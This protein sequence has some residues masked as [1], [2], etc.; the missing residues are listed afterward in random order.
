MVPL[1]IPLRLMFF[2]LLALASNVPALLA[3]SP[4]D[5]FY[6]AYYLETARG[7]V[8]GAAKLYGQV[9]ATRGAPPELVAQAKS[10]LASCDEDLAAADF[11]RLM[12]PNP[13]AYIELNRPGERVRKLLGQ[14]GLLAEADQPPVGHEK[15]VAVSPAL[16]EAFCGMRGVAAAVTGFDPAH[17]MPTG[18]VVF[19]PGNMEIARGLIETALPAGTQPTDP[20]AGYPT[21]KVADQFLVTLTNRLVIA[22]SQEA[23]I[24]AVIDRLK[25]PSADSL[26]TNEELAEIRNERGDALLFFFVNPK[27]LLPLL[28]GVLAVGASQSHEAAL[29]QA[30]L[31]IPSFR[32]LTGRFDIS[33]QGL[34][35][36]L[37]L[38]LAEGH[39]NLVYNFLRGPAIDPATLRAIPPD[40]A[41]FVAFALNEAP[42]RYREQA[43]TEGAEP[44]VMFLDLG[45]EIF[46][47]VNGI[48]VCAL[49]PMAAEP[50]AARQV[51]DVAAALTVND[52]AKSQALWGQ[53]LGIG[54]LAAGAPTMKGDALEIAGTTVH[55]YRFADE[56]TVYFATTGHHVLVG[57]TESA[58]TRALQAARGGKSVLD[59]AAFAPAVTRLGPH[60]TLA[61][62]AHPGR[63]MEI[64]RL[65]MSADEAA[66]LA[67]LAQLMTSTLASLTITH[68]DQMLRCAVA[69][70]GLPNVG[71]LVAKLL[72][73]QHQRNAQQEQL[74]RAMRARNWNQARQLQDELLKA[75][76]QNKNALRAKF[77]L[78][79]IHQDDA[80][81]AR[82]I[83]EEL[84]RR[85][86]KDANALNNF[87][88]ALLT[89]ERY[90]GKYHD[91][92]LRFARRANELSNHG[93][94]AYLD[95]LALA[96]FEAG[97][98]ERAVELEQKAIELAQRS[99]SGNVRELK[100][101][102]A[103]FQAVEDEAQE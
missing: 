78:S 72:S 39:R 37:T 2:G 69:V 64:A 11:A 82:E 47:N 42:E 20:I 62:C 29:A 27:P 51:P 90:G 10:R 74:T 63:C 26:A 6:Q 32:A 40:A 33:A 43:R 53:M 94:W 8:A 85:M 65:F 103:R 49:T 89:E 76:P 100:A 66:P 81:A 35:L 68:S 101:A 55:R 22:G 41:A 88:W 96:E 16:I 86:D 24:E 95:T 92:A 67:P 7:D 15:R 30:L 57:S 79:A 54:S 13:L 5:Q 58:I 23:E 45:R 18:V 28:Q 9:I 25:S 4:Q 12:P 70:T 102:L 34:Q 59:E 80:A 46:A 36:E 97:D 21:F 77:D 38:R 48:A 87:A 3:E 44:I 50:A 75:Q 83:A 98:R 73:E 17:R 19:H 99:R 71:G 14:L 1:T 93:N 56:V 91:V 52:P 61:A 84:L 60:T 31:D